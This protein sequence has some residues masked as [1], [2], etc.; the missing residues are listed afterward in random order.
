V[1]LDGP[2]H[3]LRHWLQAMAEHTP[4][5]RVEPGQVVTTGTLTDAWP[6]KPGQRWHTLLSDPRLSALSL[7]LA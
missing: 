3:A 7:D 2:L 5:W 6:L 1:V 4:D